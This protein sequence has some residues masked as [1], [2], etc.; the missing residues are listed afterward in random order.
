MQY[1]SSGFHGLVFFKLDKKILKF[2]LFVYS[3]KRGL[4]HEFSRKLS[5]FL[6]KKYLYPAMLEYKMHYVNRFEEICVLTFQIDL[7][8]RSYDEIPHHIT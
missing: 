4:L 1:V 3:E 8:N 2:H 6:L 5:N 7:A